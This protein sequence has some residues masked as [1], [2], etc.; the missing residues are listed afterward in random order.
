MSTSLGNLGLALRALLGPVLDE[1]FADDVRNEAARAAGEE[2]QRQAIELAPFRTGKLEDSSELTVEDGRAT[3][4]FNTDYA[5][6]AHE[7]PET[8]IG[9]GTAAKAGNELGPAGPKYLER[10]LLAMQEKF[11]QIGGE[12]LTAQ[13][14]ERV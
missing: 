14:K 9:P 2:V 11:L 13:L 4:S 12:V 1:S 7:R 8:A 6:E 5:A 10:P 3:V